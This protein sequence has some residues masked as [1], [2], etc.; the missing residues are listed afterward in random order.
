M[1]YRIYSRF[2]RLRTGSEF[3]V[4]AAGGAILQKKSKFISS[5]LLRDRHVFRRV[6]WFRL[7]QWRLYSRGSNF[8]AYVYNNS[9]FIFCD[10]ATDEEGFI[11]DPKI[12]IA[13][14][15]VFVG[16]IGLSSSVITS[17]KLTVLGA[18]DIVDRLA[19]FAQ[20]TFIVD[21]RKEP[22]TKFIPNSYWFPNCQ[23]DS[24]SNYPSIKPFARRMFTVLVVAS[25][26]DL[27]D[28]CQK[29]FPHFYVFKFRDWDS[30]GYPVVSS[31]T[32]APS[33]MAIGSCSAENNPAR[34]ARG[35]L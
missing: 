15:V 13:A 4:N 27:S 32:G 23:V 28:D 1:A 3:L 10:S 19:F 34:T 9:E 12:L 25:E 33:D 18:D 16:L 22:G 35:C 14:I 20:N 8:I 11:K 5:F 6:N 21:V 29:N 17:S 2:N 26:K 31:G 24:M 30:R 7:H